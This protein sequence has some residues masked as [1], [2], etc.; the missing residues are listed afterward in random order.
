MLNRIKSFLNNN[1]QK[2]YFSLITN[3]ILLFFIV[4]MYKLEFETNDDFTMKLLVSGAYGV[5]DYHL[6]FINVIIGKLLIF[7]YSMLPSVSWYEIIQY[8]CILFSLIQITFVFFRNN[9]NIFLYL[10]ILIIIS[11]NLYSNLQFTKTSSILTMAGCITIIDYIFNK[12]KM[13]ALFFGVLFLIFGF[14]IRSME[15]LAI[16]GI[17]FLTFVP[18]INKNN[19]MKVLKIFIII[20]LPITFFFFVDRCSYSSDGWNHYLEYNKYRVELMDRGWPSY[21]EINRNKIGINENAYKLFRKAT[22]N[23]ENVFGNELLKEIVSIKERDNLFLPIYKI[24]VFIRKHIILF[25]I[26]VVLLLL[27]LLNN[28]KTYQLIIFVLLLLLALFIDLY[29]ICILNS[30]IKERVA[31]PIIISALLILLYYSKNNFILYNNFLP[32]LIAIFAL[33]CLFC[34]D[35]S[36]INYDNRENE[37]QKIITESIEKDKIYL[38]T[39]SSRFIY[40]KDL[41]KNYEKGCFSNIVLLGGWDSNTPTKFQIQKNNGINNCFID[42]INNE[43][44]F[45]ISTENEINRIEQYIN[46]YYSNNTYSYKVTELYDNINLYSILK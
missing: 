2:Y 37:K 18:F 44:I 28:K 31:L 40:T 35:N 6:V 41:F 19:I 32:L 23:D 25:F 21:E 27:F 1:Y 4:L 17:F 36:I 12:R 16:S 15:F 20:I 45:I 10:P 39:M 11:I 3:I 42:V 9:K 29:L 5:F 7:L 8:V 43:N 14:L 22:I 24:S 38:T 26:F 33:F 34:F 46:D 30:Y 13:S